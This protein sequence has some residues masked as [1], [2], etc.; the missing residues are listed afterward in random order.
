VRTGRPPTPLLE[1]VRERR[2]DAKNK[3]HRAKLLDDDSLLEFVRESECVTT[4]YAALA[5]IQERYRRSHGTLNRSWTHSEARSFQLSLERLG[6]DGEPT[7]EALEAL[8][9]SPAA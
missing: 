1:L 9:R 3:R 5:Q 7:P 2:F 4:L 6:E 8:R